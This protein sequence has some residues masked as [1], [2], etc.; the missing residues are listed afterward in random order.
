[1]G[2]IFTIVGVISIRAAFHLE[3]N[4][5]LPEVAARKAAPDASGPWGRL[6]SEPFALEDTGQVFADGAQRLKAPR[7]VFEGYSREQLTGLLQSCELSDTEKSF[8]LDTSHWETLSRGFAISPP[9]ELVLGLSPASRQRL[10]WSL[11]TN[12]ANYPQYTPFNFLSSSVE[13]RFADSGLKPD[14]IELIRK[15]AYPG[16]GCLWLAVDRPLLQSFNADELQSLVRV[17][18]SYPSWALR[19]HVD[20]DCDVDALVKYWGKGRE[21]KLR[22]FLESLAASPNGGSAG[23]GALLPPFAQAHLNSF[24]D[25]ETD[26][27]VEHDDCFYT[28][29]NFFSN[30]PDPRFTDAAYT[31]KVLQSDYA[32]TQPPGR[33]GDVVV[34][35]DPAGNGIH[36]CAYLADGFVFT[37]NGG[38]FDQPWVIMK[39]ADV[40]A[41]YPTAGRQRVVFWRHKGM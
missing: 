13:E 26:P 9:D 33:F 35:M 28:A 40:L 25:P 22:P 38:G 37:K 16:Y 41:S 7:W 29:M 32:V 34:V 19:I 24:P 18:Y 6:E 5:A 11:A 1:M 21:K 10:F 36:A 3:T 2:A 20:R 30:Q 15:L 12:S 39:L 27:A 17:L 8:L 4:P 23:V 31:K 14:K